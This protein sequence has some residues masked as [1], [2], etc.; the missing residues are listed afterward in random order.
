MNKPENKPR[1]SAGI[2]AVWNDIAVGE[3][4]DFND[5]YLRQHI[6][7]RTGIPGFHIARR[8]EAVDGGPRN[9]SYYETTTPDVLLTPAY[10]KRLN[11]P[12]AWTKA[13]MPRFVGMNRTVARVRCRFG[14]GTAGMAATL[15]FSPG[16]ASP[17]ALDGWLASEALPRALEIPGITRVE[18]WQGDEQIS[19]VEST[20]RDLRGG[21]DEVA[22][23]VLMAHGADLESVD[24]LRAFLPPD[25]L[26]EL[27]AH[28]HDWTPYRLL[29]AL[30]DD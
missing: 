3:E 25:K 26:L 29:Y 12:T 18:Y 10:L 21:D 15:E 8:Y 30:S 27:G 11:N 17:D 16:S 22:G 23:H 20:E 4:D 9:F 7:E 14:A 13:N 5:W 2:L 1:E 24:R 28:A 19:R 6:P